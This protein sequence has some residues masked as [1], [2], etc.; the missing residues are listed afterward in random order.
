MDKIQRIIES[1][2]MHLSNNDILENKLWNKINKDP[3][4]RIKINTGWRNVIPIIIII[5]LKFY[6]ISEVYYGL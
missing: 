5:Q 3:F 2:T 1:H 6:K 4:H